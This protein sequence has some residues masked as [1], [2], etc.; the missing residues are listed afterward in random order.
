MSPQLVKQLLA[1]MQP[2]KHGSPDEGYISPEAL[3]VNS[4]GEHLF[5]GSAFYTG[6]QLVDD[7][8]YGKMAH[9]FNRKEMEEYV[10]PRWIEKET[11]KRENNLTPK[12]V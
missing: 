12:G 9:I 5:L 11:L 2:I 7:S 4:I 1:L 6:M 8:G 3:R 10:T